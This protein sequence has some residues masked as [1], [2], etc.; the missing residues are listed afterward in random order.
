MFCAK[1]AATKSN[2]FEK[3]NTNKGDKKNVDLMVGN[4]TVIA[5]RRKRII[6]APE[7]TAEAEYK[8]GNKNG[9]KKV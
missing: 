7:C 3:Y 4:N 9:N 1:M 2:D 8:N 5:V 6:I